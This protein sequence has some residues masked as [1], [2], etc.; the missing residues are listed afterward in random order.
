MKASHPLITSVM[1]FILLVF[2]GISAACAGEVTL[3]TPQSEYYVLAGEEAVIP[4]TIASTYD[5][6][7][8]GTL[9]QSTLLVNSGTAGFHAATLQS[10]AFSAF[11]ETRTVS[12]PVVKSDVPADYLLT[13]SFMYQEGGERTSTLGEI[14]IHFVTSIENT[15]GKQKTL[16][17]TD[18]ANPAAGISS[19][20][21]TAPTENPATTDPSAELQN[22][23]MSQ[24]TSALRDQLAGEKNES[25]NKENDLLEYIRADPIIVSLDHSLTGAGFTP[26]KTDIT[27][28][29][30][31]SG[32][33]LLTYSSGAK[34]AAIKGSLVDTRVL[35]AE[36]SSDASI[37]LPE[38]L[39]NNTTY[40]EYDT[41]ALQKGFI[42]N[43]TRIN[44]TPG[45]ETVDITYT[46]SRNRFIHLKAVLQ[47]G[48]V[49]TVE[50]E[51][52]DDLLA[53][54]IPV[55]ALVSV[56]LISTGIWYLARIR[57]KD[58]PL[59]SKPV[60][61][62]EPG[63]SPR[64]VARHLLDEAESDAARGTWPEAYR[65]TGRALRI[66]LSHEISQGNEL[67]S[68]EVERLIRTYAGNTGKV[69]WLL[70]RCRSVGFAKDSPEPGEFD[71]MIRY[72]R[73]LLKE[74]FNGIGD[75]DSKR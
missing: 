29:S 10:R 4:L 19:G 52:P 17:G 47:N 64:E 16:I 68:G 63:K 58:L 40:Q 12:L 38:S 67:T 9:K 49:A 73:T 26:D 50:G 2:L 30:N 33:F 25:D 69:R 61:G 55:I 15:P 35:F 21:S 31:R 3:S 23:Q 36:E 28:V 1:I 34:T 11:T 14:G 74:D 27:P 32:S 71:D 45:G 56:V 44:V 65:K 39:L 43:Q 53:S 5:H 18:T 75:P 72:T 7:I 70:D 48:T 46:D 66:Y 42:R 59:R 51:N 8:S 60:P 37:P 54:L 62:P 13:I 24:D 41:R 57:S 22:N 6:D 20:G